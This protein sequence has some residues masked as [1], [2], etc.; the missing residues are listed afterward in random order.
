[1]NTADLDFDLP[2]RLIARHPAERRGDARLLVVEAGADR[3]SHEA[4]SGLPGHL[5][6]GDLLVL[7]DTKVLPA[8]LCLKKTTG[9]EVEGLFLEERNARFARCMLSGGRLRPGVQ[10]TWNGRPVL[11]LSQKL[12]RGEWI[13]EKLLDLPWNELLEDIGATPLP[14]YIR[15]LR[16]AADESLDSRDDRARYQTVWAQQEGSVA[17]PTASLHFDEG[18]LQR[19]HAGGVRIERLTLHVGQGTFLPVECEMVEDHP[20]HAEAFVVGPE[21][22]AALQETKDCGGRVFAAGT[23]VCRALEAWARGDRGSTE[24]MILPGFDFKVVDGLLTNFHTPRSTLLALVAAMAQAQGGGD[25]LA[26]VLRAYAEA[27]AEN[28]RFFSYGD[29]SLWLPRASAS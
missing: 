14:P 27:I 8:R 22:E 3:L 19:L 2:E 28:Y 20:M 15:R 26:F 29:A 6:E 18:M 7:N 12:E 17:A 25:G 1:M 9:G 11:L 10:L 4:F 16:E 13:L 24:L 5:R 23:T 21:L